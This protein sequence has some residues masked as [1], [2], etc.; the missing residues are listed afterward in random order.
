M[1]D[2]NFIAELVPHLRQVGLFS[3]CSDYELKV[4]AK[5]CKLRAVPVGE[6]V[7]AMGEEGVEMF[8]VLSG[9]AAVTDAA[10]HVLHTFQIG[11]HFGELAVLRPA[12]RT[13]SMPS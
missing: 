4:V 11:E 2:S 7:I 6:K 3:R 12:P 1:A 10:G 5:N 9:S 8:L 13:S